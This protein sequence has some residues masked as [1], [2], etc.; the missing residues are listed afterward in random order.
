MSF[1][2]TL[3][4]PIIGLAPMDGVTDAA[5]RFMV[6]QHGKP[7]VQCTEFVSVEEIRHGTASAWRQLRFVERERPILAQIYGADPDGFYQ[8]TQV[9]CA[10][11]FDGVDIN[12]GCPAKSVSGRGCGAA[13]IRNPP[14]ARAIIRAV[15]AGV[16]DWVSGHAIE[17]IGLRPG[18]VEQVQRL[19]GTATPRHQRRALPVSIKTRLGYDTVVIE[20]WVSML[21]E[22]QPEVIAIHGRTLA[23]R[24]RGQA[25]WDAIRRAAKL[26]R[27]TSTLVLGNGDLGTMLEVVQ[28]VRETRVHGVLIGRGALG[29]PWIF[30]ATAWARQQCAMLTTEAPPPDV[31]VGERC[32][33]ALE[34]ARYFEGLADGVPFQAMRKHLG[35]Y[36]HGFPGA[37]DMR[38]RLFTTTTSGDV[39][40]VFATLSLESSVDRSLYKICQWPT[41]LSCSHNMRLAQ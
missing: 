19:T 12:M 35:W 38:A 6:A 36:C 41:T 32:Q 7:D 22:E 24:Y 26:V 8:V 33:V 10:L 27:E 29:N 20:D 17:T 18:V 34:H 2:H 28:R 13:L 40:Q 37:A 23:Q 25:D 9:L 5:F 16:R 3:P 31:S 30:R 15:Q 14:L 4:Q 1:W 21:L 39:A 11:G